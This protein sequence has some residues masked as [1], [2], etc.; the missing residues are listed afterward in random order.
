MDFDNDDAVALANRLQEVV[1]ALPADTHPATVMLALCAML[2]RGIRLL[3]AD[4]REKAFI[5]ATDL[6]RLGAEIDPPN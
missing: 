1:R 2:A 3:D 4:E 5:W 6:I